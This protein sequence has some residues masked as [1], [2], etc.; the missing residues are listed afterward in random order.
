MYKDK[1]KMGRWGGGGGGEVL[2]WINIEEVIC[3]R[4]YEGEYI[5]DLL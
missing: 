3:C 2:Q 5:I 4:G 1:R